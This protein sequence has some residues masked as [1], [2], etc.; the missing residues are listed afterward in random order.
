MKNFKACLCIYVFLFAISNL[1]A[2]KINFTEAPEDYRLYARDASDSALVFISGNIKG[3]PDFEEYSLKVFKDDELFVKEMGS[4][5]NKK[6][7][8]STKIN[9]GLHKYRFEFYVRKNNKDNLY[10][11]AD[12]IVCGDAYIITGQSNS[13]ASSPL[14]TYS[15]PYCRSFGVKTGFELYNNEDQEV[16]WG[17]ASGNCPDLKKDIG[18]WFTKNPYGVG[19]WGMELM[20]LIVEKYK[21]PVC[22]INGGS[23][24]SSIEE[25]MLYPEQSSLETSFGRLAYRVNQ[26]GLKDK[27]KAVFWHQGESNSNTKE[28]VQAY[29]S[30]FDNLLK[31]WKRVYTG[32]EKIYLFQLHP[33]C[34]QSPES[35]GGE[36]RDLQTHITEKY[37]MI[38]IMST[39]GVPGHDGCHFS[40]EGYLEFARRIFPLVSRDFY[41]QTPKGMISPPKLVKAQYLDK[42]KIVLEFD[43]AVV[44]E[45]KKEVKGKECFLKDQFFFDFKDDSSTALGIINRIEVKDKNVILTLNKESDFKDVTYLPNKFYTGTTTIY[46]GPWLN[47]AENNIGALSFY[48]KPILDQNA[49]SNKEASLWKG[50]KMIDSTLNGVKFKIVFPKKANANKHWIWRARFWGHEPQT[51]LALLEQGF[52]LV[53]IE[54]GGLFGNERAMKIWDGFYEYVTNKYKLNSKVVLE[55]MSRGGLIIFNWGNRNA[56]KVACIY[57]DA[58]VC[59]FKSWPAG[60]GKG[61]GSAGAWASCLKAYGFSEEV[62]LLYNGNP[63]NH[64][65]NLASHQVTILCVVGDVDTVV[66]FAENT[67]LLQKRLISM[68][69]DLTIIHKPD[70]GHHPHSFKDPKPIV[71]F[72][73]LNTQK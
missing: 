64:M 2:Q 43:Q 67:A 46:N 5:E 29:E 28:S 42:T 56:E 66:P 58:P 8:I 41:N 73:L 17:L 50:F 32:L 36:M 3:E 16:R 26:A 7:S 39:L 54:V 48:K 34:G 69:W 25:N 35:F 4:L 24:S 59:D 68:D 47:G 61:E 22:I 10:F 65:E 51:D 44:L 23:G 60:K 21:V 18:G 57:A 72:I 70:V 38:D 52:H 49:L 62:A 63:I 14:S 12:N 31:D 71:D 9:S 53:Y 45:D 33:G 20:R 19:V 40:Y 55:G 6:F 30:N 11:V 27:I 13:H 1:F 15:N 37:D